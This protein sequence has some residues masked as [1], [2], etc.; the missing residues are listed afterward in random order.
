MILLF[1]LLQGFRHFF[2][3]FDKLDVV[4]LTFVYFAFIIETLR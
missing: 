2:S 3:G 1:R 4:F